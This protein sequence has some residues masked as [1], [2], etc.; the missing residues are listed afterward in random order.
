MLQWQVVYLVE[1]LHGLHHQ[2]YQR[3]QRLDLVR[4]VA[5]RHALVPLYLIGEVKSS[6]GAKILVSRVI[7]C[8]R[9]GLLQ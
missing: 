3:L 6:G 7:H 4:A 8:F 5:L 2:H 9:D 1:N